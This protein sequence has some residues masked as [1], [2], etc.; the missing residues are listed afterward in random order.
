[1]ARAKIENAAFAHVPGAAA[2]KPLALVPPFLKDDGIRCGNMKWFVIHFSLRDVPLSRQPLGDRVLG[3]E[4]TDMARFAVGGSTKR[5][6]IVETLWSLSS[7]FLPQVHKHDLENKPF[8]GWLAF[9]NGWSPAGSIVGPDQQ[10]SL[11]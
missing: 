9:S 6:V 11:R 3:Q 1:V 5:F 8:N 7:A 4:S 2:S 10:R